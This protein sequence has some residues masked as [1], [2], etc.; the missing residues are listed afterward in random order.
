MKPVLVFVL[1]AAAAYSGSPAEHMPTIA[2]FLSF[3]NPAA[4]IS[5]DSMKQEA[6]KVLLTAEIALDWRSL[7]EN[8]G[9]EPAD[10]L[11]VLRFKGTCQSGTTSPDDDTALLG[12]IVLASTKI[13]DGR[14]LPFGEVE[15]DRI[16]DYISHMQSG[17]AS[18]R[19]HLLGRVLGRIV[20]HEL[21]HIVARTARHSHSFPTQSVH[22]AREFALK[23]FKFSF[24]ARESELLHYP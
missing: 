23:S 18:Q 17:S 1:F 14:V 6:G 5:V 13:S 22:T 12:R 24:S 2:V 7:Q 15:C 11:A 16:R 4:E 21:F 3:D 10:A 20:A 19:E 8:R 9:D